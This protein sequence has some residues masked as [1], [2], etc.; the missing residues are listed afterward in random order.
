MST[1][2]RIF[3]KFI[4]FRVDQSGSFDCHLPDSIVATPG[5][6]YQIHH[7]FNDSAIYLDSEINKYNQENILE[8]YKRNNISLLQQGIIKWTDVK[9][10]T[11][12]MV[13]EDYCVLQC[14]K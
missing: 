3:F 14:V 7:S 10:F 8:S 4:N 12:E 1:P 11:H 9:G 13:T 5:N 6:K 2:E